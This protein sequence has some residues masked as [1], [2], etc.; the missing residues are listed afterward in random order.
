MAAKIASLQTQILALPIWAVQPRHPFLGQRTKFMTVLTRIRTT[1]G[2]EGFGYFF[3]NDESQV[4]S[5]ELIVRQLGERLVGMEAARRSHIHDL[6]WNLC[7]ELMREGA[8][9]LAMS[10]IDIAL[11]DIFGKLVGLPLADV[12]GRRHDT[13]GAYGSHLLGRGCEFDQLQTEAT[14]LLDQGFRAMKVRFRGDS[15]DSD[16]AR[17]RAV[18]ECVGPEV[19]IFSDALW[20]LTPRYA[21]E[22]SDRILDYRL[23]WLED[24]LHEENIRDLK[25]LRDRSKVPIASGER[26]SR[27]SQIEPMLDAVDHLIVDIQHIGGIT[28]FLKAAALAEIRGIPVSGHASYEISLPLLASMKNPGYLEYVP[29]LDIIYKEPPRL[30]DGRY[31]VSRKP[32]LGLE[33]NDSEIRRLQIA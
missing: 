7:F 15:I 14:Q 2:I 26:I 6:M 27:L 8:A 19:Q 30:I 25:W 29:P 11:W 33:L 31:P 12:L 20:S 16:V 9:N 22:L 21:E 23:M 28:P 5:V 10:T 4:R 18:R 32:G 3:A 1:E 24:P 13:V 17:A